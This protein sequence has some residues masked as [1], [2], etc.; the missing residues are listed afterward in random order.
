MLKDSLIEEISLFINQR[1]DFLLLLKET[2]VVI[3]RA[4]LLPLLRNL[5]KLTNLLKTEQLNKKFLN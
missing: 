4:L 1:K 5:K 3:K 2:F